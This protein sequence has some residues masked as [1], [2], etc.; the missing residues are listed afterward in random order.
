MHRMNINKII[1]LL[2]FR[3][4]FRLVLIR[5]FSLLIFLVVAGSVYGQIGV[6]A[7]FGIEADTRSGDVLSG[8]LT[9]DW[10]YNGIS[11]AGVI[12]EATAISN[13]YAAQLA[14]GNN[15]AFDLS[16]SIPNYASNSGY[17][18]YSTRYGRDYTNQSSN[19]LTIFTSG[20]NGDD[21][22]TSWGA[23]SGSVPS[24]TD[25]VDTGVHMRRDGINVT[26]DLWVDMMV[27]TLSSSGSH[28]IDFELFVS[29]VALSGSGF[30]NSGSQEGHTAWTFDGSGNVTNIGDMV[31]GF[32][33]GGGGVSGLEIR[34]WVDRSIFNPGSS[35]GGTST[36]TWGSNI[37]GGS[38]Y[39]YGEIIVPVA[40]LL[41]NVNALSTAAPPWGTTNTSGYTA[42]YSSDYFA[43]VGINFTQL[44]F[45]PRALFGS[46]AACDSPFSAILTKSRTSSSFTSSLKDF[47][48]PYDFLGSAAGTQVNTT[49]TDPGSF[50]SCASGETFTL[51]AEFIS[52]TAEYIWYSLTP[53]VVFPA[54]GLSEI[55]GVGMDNVL[56]DTPGDYQ[57]GIAPLLG[58]SP[59]TEPTNI[60][61]VNASPCAVMDS[62]NAVENTTLNISAKGVL[63]NDTDLETG[64]V[65]TVNTTPV[66]DV[67][68]GTLTLSTDGSFTYIPNPGFTGVDSFTYQVCDDSNSNLCDTAVVTITVSNDND[69]DGVG[70][71]DD[72]DDDNDGILDTVESN[73]IDP[74]G[75]AD[76]DGMP[77]YQDPDFCSLNAFSIC[78][79]LDVDGDGIPNHF[80]LDSDG[81][82]CNDVLEGGFTDDNNDGILAELPTTV[83]VN[84]QVTGTNRVD[85]YTAPTDADS[86]GTADYLESGAAPSIN[87]Q[88][89]N[90]TVFD[91]SGTNFTVSANDTNTYQWQLSIDEGA[92]FTDLT[93]GATYLGTNTSTLTLSSVALT[94][95]KYQYRV[96]TSNSAYYC[97][98]PLTSD[99]ATLFV[100]V[101]TVITNSR[102]TY[103][104]KKN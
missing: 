85:G 52:T 34:I 13:G 17:I 62:Y 45:D 81:D 83:D 64:D 100:R 94:M 96:I 55:S 19:D 56:I 3:R 53:G 67:T 65:L 25:I 74:S 48:G 1:N 12:D 58:C 22:T 42:N 76:N 71:I 93:D 15:I 31:I 75:D 101:R 43:E 89:T 30:I 60:I 78:T 95:N 40:A 103:R 77:N 11:G 37:D 98:L 27:S 92:T 24:K 29:K 46:G 36:F 4:C 69:G 8:V 49:I 84:G 6:G 61:S 7:N 68:N 44:G 104:I 33:F 59:T 99:A 88:P 90:V 47:A 97:A 26:D 2:F 72:L 23:G 87:S 57:L 39:G 9:D 70:D 54:N 66:V 10:F 79:N 63:A 21:P 82:G 5:R 32:A 38:T 20:K 14:A 51:Q 73:G 16:Q 35:P 86:S 102:I 18:W 41:N 28:F 80:D 91:G 50:D